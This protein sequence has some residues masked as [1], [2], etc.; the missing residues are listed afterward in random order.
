MFENSSDCSHKI[1]NNLR[2]L[3]ALLKN[4]LKETLD[5]DTFDV[6]QQPITDSAFLNE[7]LQVVQD[8]ELEGAPAQN[9]L[10]SNANSVTAAVI[11]RTADLDKAAEA[12]VNARFAFKGRSPYA[13]DVVLVNEFIKKE[14]LQALVRHSISLGE[15][16]TLKNRALEKQKKTESG[17]TDLVADLQR[18]GD[19]RV[20]AQET[21]SAI[22]DSRQRLVMMWLRVNRRLMF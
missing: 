11:D 5:S 18:N 3:P 22:V 2:S 12:L 14:F 16:V 13:P 6:A 10:F 15:G 1:E 9:Q 4:V 17:L 8:H 21:G 20:I 7:C 19:I